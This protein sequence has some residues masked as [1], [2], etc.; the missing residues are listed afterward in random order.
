MNDQDLIRLEEA[1]QAYLEIYREYEDDIIAAAESLRN[2]LRDNYIDFYKD[3]VHNYKYRWILRT[4]WIV[5]NDE[6]EEITVEFWERGRSG[7]QD[8]ILHTIPIKTI[9]IDEERQ[10]FINKWN[11][12][13]GKMVEDNKAKKE[14]DKQA[15]IR[16]LEQQ[17]AN[18]KGE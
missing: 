9:I 12:E 7:D 16:R 6:D 4:D 15:Q 3:Y 18:L 2:Q 5:I 10:T 8:E 14:Q 13:I 11:T 1:H 17:L